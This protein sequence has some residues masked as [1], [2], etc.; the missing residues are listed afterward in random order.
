MLTEGV[1]C[2]VAASREGIVGSAFA[3]VAGA[4]GVIGR[5]AVADPA[6]VTDPLL[7][8]LEATLLEQGARKLIC[9]PQAWRPGRPVGRPRLRAGGGRRARGAHPP[10]HGDRPLRRGTARRADGRPGAVG[11]PARDGARQGDHRAAGHSSPVRAGPGEPSRRGPAQGERA[12]RSAR[13]RQDHL[14]EGHRLTSAMAV[15]RS[16]PGRA[17]RRRR[18][19]AGR[20]TGG[21]LR[22]HPR[23]GLGRRVRRRG[24]G[25]RLRSARGPPGRL[26]RDER[27]SP[28]DPAAAGQAEP[29]ARLRH[30]LGGPPRSDFPASGPV[31]LRAARR[32]A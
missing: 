31:R 24:G 26:Q 28:P 7:D 15:R 4:L 8:R 10:T 3:L 16:Q 9:W 23:P 22:A 2:L 14:R 19:A 32:A 5:I 17:R 27:V 29:C 21:P 6:S 13:H 1:V 12:V 18:G 11:P 30:E 25:P 20:S